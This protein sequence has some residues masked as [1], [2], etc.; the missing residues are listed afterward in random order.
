[1]NGGSFPPHGSQ[2]TGNDLDG[3]FDGYNQ[4]DADTA[5]TILG[6]LN[7]PT[8]GS[9][10]QTI[11]VTFSRVETIPFGLPS[12]TADGRQAKDVIRSAG[13]HTTHFHYRISST[14][15]LSYKE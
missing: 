11:F 10:I 7:D 5:A 8:Y 3:W 15:L 1:M 14:V 4:R 12:N 9:H 2:Q 6:H 13:G